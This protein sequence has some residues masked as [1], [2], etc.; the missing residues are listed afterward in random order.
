MENMVIGLLLRPLIALLVL[1][2]ITRPIARAVYKR[3]KDGRL[4]RLLFT[5]LGS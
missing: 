3:M 4:K 1:A 2:C 5:R